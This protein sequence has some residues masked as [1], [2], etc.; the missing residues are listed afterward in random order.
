MIGLHEMS[1]QNMTSNEHKESVSRVSPDTDGDKQNNA[2]NRV[3]FGLVHPEWFCC[4]SCLC[5]FST[6]KLIKRIKCN[7]NKKGNLSQSPQESKL[8]K[9]QRT[10][11]P[12]VK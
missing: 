11:W 7:S 5:T 1:L 6:T 2:I 10:I 9:T 4:L 12:T 8:N 3:V